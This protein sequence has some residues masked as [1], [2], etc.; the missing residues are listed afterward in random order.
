MQSTARLA[1]R[2]LTPADAVPVHSYQAQEIAVRFVPFAARTLDQVV[3]AL[4]RQVS[5]P[6]L[7]AVGE[8]VIY[9]AWSTELGRLVGQFNLG[10]DLLDPK[11]GSFGYL[12]HPE[13]WR[14]GYALEATRELLRHAF[15]DRGYARVTAQIDVRNQ[16]SI[17]L[18]EKLGMRREATFMEHDRLKGELVSEHIYAMLAREWQG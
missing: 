10:V 8:F 17:N 14:R 12:V 5:S 16:A 18:A 11:T 3:E 1:Y 15:V 13:F 7:S 4:N 6:E 9:G 2:P